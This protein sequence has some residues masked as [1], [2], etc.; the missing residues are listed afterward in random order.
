MEAAAQYGYCGGAGRERMAAGC[1]GEF[2]AVDD[3]LVLPY[4]DEDEGDGE[5]PAVVDA[6]AV[7]KEEAGLG[8]L[9][10]DSSTVTAA[11]HSCS[12]SISGLADGDLSGELCEPVRVLLRPWDLF[13][14]N[15]C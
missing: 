3:L 2:F 8:N 1:A 14:L 7:V 12:N 5:A 15:S 6:A 9:S 10:A 4:D 11:L 13:R